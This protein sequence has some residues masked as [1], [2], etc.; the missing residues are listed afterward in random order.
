MVEI[1]VVF[2]M[3]PTA[4][5]KSELAMALAARF[6]VEI[7]SVDSAL[8]YRGMDIGTAKPS[9]A[10]RAQIPHHLIDIRDPSES[11]SAAAFCADARRCIREIRGRGRLPLLVGGTMLYFR[12]LQEGLAELPDADP[13][14]R[15][16][17]NRRAAEQ[18]WAQ[19]HAELARVDPQSGRRIHPNDPQRIQRA[20][21][22]YYLSGQP[23]SELLRTSRVRGWDEVPL[24]WV[25][26]PADRDQ[27]R[28]RIAQ[29]FDTMIAQ[30]LEQEA[31]SL[32]DRRDFHPDL[33]AMRAVGYRQFW[34]YFEG[35]INFDT[36]RDNAITATCQ[37]AKRQMT[38]LRREQNARWYDSGQSDLPVRL[39]ETLK[40]IGLC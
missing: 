5:G 30:G 36:L 26:A 4:S 35:K 13:A 8:V 27:L 29:R 21:E 1:P 3:G 14:L 37:L 25:I 6:P 15:E 24:K 40:E 34:P 2:L 23:L 38:W 28:R 18:G 16:S 9:P 17:L 39:I 7:V 33:P 32:F 19:L 20:L 11:Y 22:V 31:R 12:A 10:L